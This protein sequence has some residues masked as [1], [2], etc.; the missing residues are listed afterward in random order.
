MAPHPPQVLSENG[1]MYTQTMINEEIDIK[2]IMEE[3]LKG[4]CWKIIKQTIAGTNDSLSTNCILKTH[5]KRYLSDAI[6]YKKRVP[7]ECL[8]NTLNYDMLISKIVAIPTK[9]H[10]LGDNQGTTE[11]HGELSE[12]LT[13]SHEM[14]EEVCRR[15]R[16]MLRV[17]GTSC[18]IK[19]NTRYACGF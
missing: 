10:D 16:V 1:K 18:V 11:T 2:E 17:N 4:V 9:D 19:S 6:S 3:Y 12:G 7:W 15:Q 13:D 8:F 5:L 14:L